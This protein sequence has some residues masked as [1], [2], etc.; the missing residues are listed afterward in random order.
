MKKYYENGQEFYLGREIIVM[1]DCEWHQFESKIKKIQEDYEGNIGIEKI[2]IYLNNRNITDYKISRSALYVI[3]LSFPNNNV[4][5]ISFASLESELSMMELELKNKNILFV[6][7]ESDKIILENAWGK[8]Y[9]NEKINFSIISLDGADNFRH[10]A[11][12][13]KLDKF[14]KII[15]FL[16]DYDDKGLS[17]YKQI[18]PNKCNMKDCSTNKLVL[19]KTDDGKIW[20]MLLPVPDFRLDYISKT[21]LGFLCIELL[22]DDKKLSEYKNQV[23]SF[24]EEKIIYDRKIYKIT[25]KSDTKIKFANKT[26]YFTTEDFANF[27]PLFEKIKEILNS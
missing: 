17:V 22:F 16:N 9:L 14:N 12:L 24:Y 13:G 21:D 3:L 7:G 1:F 23:P 25:E 27:K 5:K 15:I 2:S 10:I 8:T 4:K 26:R 19:K 6:E 20:G 18:K 11:N